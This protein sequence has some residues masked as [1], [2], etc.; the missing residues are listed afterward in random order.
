[1]N[2]KVE[3]LKR[4]VIE[5]KGI[6]PY[7]NLNEKNEYVGWVSDFHFTFSDGNQMCLDLKN[8]RDMFLL[9]V[10]A[11]AWSRSGRW[12]NAAYFV[13]YLKHCQ[14]DTPEQWLD[15][16]FV[17]KQKKNR[18]KAAIG[19]SDYCVGIESRV[20]IS[21]RIDIYDS[22]VVLARHWKDILSVLSESDRQ[23]DYYSFIEYMRNISGLGVGNKR[24]SMKILLILRELRC[25]GIYKNIP[26]EFCCVPDARVKNACEK[27]NITL[28]V[29]STTK[30]LVKASTI[31][32][33]QFGNLYDIP[34]FAYED[35]MIEE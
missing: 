9:F 29:I 2:D 16:S 6:L 22:V 14:L 1:M 35:L 5:N 13:A 4:K 26:G 11:V 32:Y 18:G 3:T 10:L 19:L 23:K 30:G 8:D 12:E 33:Q 7:I 31:L 34:P 17:E 20:K 28:P 27:L 15:E 25:Q 24:M 21:F